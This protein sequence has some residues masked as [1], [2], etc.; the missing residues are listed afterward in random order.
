MACLIVGDRKIQIPGVLGETMFRISPRCFSGIRH[1]VVGECLKDFII[2]V[3]N[4]GALAKGKHIPATFDDENIKRDII[5]G[6]MNHDRRV[7]TQYL[8]K[9]RKYWEDR[10]SFPELLWIN[11]FDFF[12]SEIEGRVGSEWFKLY[13]IIRGP[14]PNDFPTP[15]SFAIMIGN[16]WDWKVHKYMRKTIKEYFKEH[17]ESIERLLHM[18]IPMGMPLYNEIGLTVEE[19]YS[20]AI[21]IRIKSGEKRKKD[22]VLSGR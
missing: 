18:E 10:Y 17:P 4:G 8:K 21:D 3:N 16:I 12:V 6:S 7:Q 15:I 20:E 2:L 14:I 1:E 11:D 9:T 5:D 22:L 19:F 13:E